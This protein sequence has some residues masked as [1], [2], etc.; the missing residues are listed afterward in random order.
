MQRHVNEKISN[1]NLS[2]RCAFRLLFGFR[3]TSVNEMDSIV[4]VEDAC[5]HSQFVLKS[6]QFENFKSYQGTYEIS[7]FPDTD[8]LVCVIGPNGS[9]KSNIMDAVAFCFNVADSSKLRGDGNLSNLIC[10]ELDPDSSASIASVTVSLTS[11]LDVSDMSFTRSINSRN[12]SRYKVNGRVVTLEKYREEMVECGLDVKGNFLVFQGDVEALALS[13]PKELGEI[14]DRVSGS[15]AYRK[16]YEALKLEK[17]V[18]ETRLSVE[19]SNRKKLLNDKKRITN[20]ANDISK[21]K[22]LKALKLEEQTM[23]YLTRLFV[24]NSKIENLKTNKSPMSSD[25]R[26][27]LDFLKSDRAKLELEIAK[28]SRK[29]V[30]MESDLIELGSKIDEKKRK[31]ESCDILKILKQVSLQTDLNESMRLKLV[32]LDD[33]IKKIRLEIFEEEKNVEKMHARKNFDFCEIP[34]EL[35][36][37]IRRV[38]IPFGTMD[39]SEA[40]EVADKDLLIAKSKSSV[41]ENRLNEIS[42]QLERNSRLELAASLRFTDLSS[43]YEGCMSSKTL[44]LKEFE[45]LEK[46]LKKKQIK[47]DRY[48]SEKSDLVEKLSQYRE[49]QEETDRERHLSET[50]FQLILN[51]G[52][53][54]VLGRVSDFLILRNQKYSLAIQ[55]AAGKYLDAIFVK[56]VQAASECVAWLKREK[57]GSCV[58]IPVN[59]LKKNISSNLLEFIEPV[60][61]SVL[62]GLNFVLGDTVVCETLKEARALVFDMNSSHKVVT[63]GGE[64]IVN[65]TITVGS[66]GNSK[67]KSFNVNETKTKLESIESELIAMRNEGDESELIRAKIRGYESESTFLKTQMDSAK[68]EWERLNESIAVM[69]KFIAETRTEIDAIGVDMMKKTKQDLVGKI[70]EKSMEIASEI[71][72]NSAFLINEELLRRVVEPEDVLR[73]EALGKLRQVLAELEKRASS[74]ECEKRVVE[75]DLNEG[76]LILKN[77]KIDQESIEKRKLGLEKELAKMDTS[78]LGEEEI[79]ESKKEI[80]G[81]KNLKMSTEMKIKEI[82]ELLSLQRETEFDSKELE[83]VMSESV[84]VLK[85]SISDQIYIPLKNISDSREILESFFLSSNFEIEMDFSKIGRHPSELI[86]LDRIKELDLEID[87]VP[88]I[89]SNSGNIDDVE[90][91]L[92]T[93]SIEIDDLKAKLTLLNAEYTRVLQVRN[94]KFLN[95]FNFIN[96]KVDQLYKSLNGDSSCASLDLETGEIFSS[97]IIFSLMPPYKR[98]TNIELLSGG[99]KTVAALALSFSLLAFSNPPFSIVDEIDAALDA[100]NVQV[101]ARFMKTAVNHQL[102]VISLKEKMYTQADCLIGVYKDPTTRSSTIVTMDL[103]ECHHDIRGPEMTPGRS[104]GISGA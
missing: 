55:T 54:K 5:V 74:L 72:K 38:D 80:S 42:V 91:K 9:G 57:K 47:I 16:E 64:K 50:V 70:R 53:E 21:L 89:H 8:A 36:E 35:I 17:T 12:E 94:S 69:A 28:K 71:L 62:S 101:L 40:L 19:N 15:G 25:L 29:L 33:K 39:I 14:V 32:G 85:Q 52:K 79:E 67:L 31:I 20:E 104:L 100:D 68:F 59:D 86:H 1:S 23:Y 13:T 90:E 92:K 63:V 45:K 75:I 37:K 11:K 24:L 97:G 81:K 48:E 44:E 66:N 18:L 95:C 30:S 83:T 61:P 6:I 7:P 2:F 98:Y 46:I 51:I 82:L 3:M 78:K 58:F 96:R 87:N 76:N 10:K 88:L 102:I 56:D 4:P 99:E 93:N 60:A 65:G 77:L 22:G 84:S 34:I 27:Q 103:R 49:T 43:Q 26:L 41:L 73:E